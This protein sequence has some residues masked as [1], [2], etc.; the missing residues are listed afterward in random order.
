MTRRKEVI[1]HTVSLVKAGLIQNPCTVIAVFAG[2]GISVD[3]HA[4]RFLTRL[5]ALR[6][7]ANRFIIQLTFDNGIGRSIAN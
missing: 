2:F 7:F 4:G 5:R 1:I 3:A 6:L